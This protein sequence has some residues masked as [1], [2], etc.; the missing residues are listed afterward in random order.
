ME[1]LKENI[2]F[3]LNNACFIDEY[4]LLGGVPS[5]SGR[6][7]YDLAL[8][9]TSH[10]K[11]SPVRFQTERPLTEFTRLCC[12]RESNHNLPFHG[13][14]SAG[15]VCV[16]IPGESYRS[17]YKVLVIRVRDLIA[18]SEGREG[19][20]VPWTEWG[21]KVTKLSNL[22]SN[23]SVLHSQVVY[24]RRGSKPPELYVHDF[25]PHLKLKDESNF[26]DTLERTRPTPE[27]P[28]KIQLLHEDTE[29]PSRYMFTVTEGGVYALRVS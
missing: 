15:I 29:Y 14:L 4:R 19:T 10:K 24:F 16:G 6:N 11:P 23:F 22:P 3:A 5:Q 27:I 8:W 20:T 12:N 13:D 25:S 26:N 1:L 9:D 21:D 7:E 2:P 17:P 18:F 28:K